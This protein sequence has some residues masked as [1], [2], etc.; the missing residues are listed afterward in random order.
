MISNL[1]ARYGFASQHNISSE[2]AVS[3]N[4]R[5]IALERLTKKKKKKE[6]KRKTTGVGEAKS[7]C[8]FLI[9][10]QFSPYDI[11]PFQ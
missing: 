11:V 2:T 8:F 9:S 7:G 5:N 4:N 6:K 10:A 1:G 3:N